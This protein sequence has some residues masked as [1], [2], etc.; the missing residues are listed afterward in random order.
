MPGQAGSEV[1]QNERLVRFDADLYA[2][3]RLFVGA[4]RGRHGTAMLPGAVLRRPI[5]GSRNPSCDAEHGAANCVAIERRLM[6]ASLMHHEHT[7]RQ[8]QHLVEIA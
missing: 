2:R 7:R 4:K 3:M 5:V 6:H 1:K 8:R